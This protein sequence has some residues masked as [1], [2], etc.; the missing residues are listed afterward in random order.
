MVIATE[1]LEACRPRTLVAALVPVLLAS[2]LAARAEVFHPLAALLCLLFAVLLQI[3]TNFANDYYDGIKGT[4]G[5]GRLGPRRG[6]G[7]GAISASRMKDAMVGVLGAAFLVGLGLVTFGGWWLLPLGL[8][9][10]ALAVGYTGGPY[11]LAY[12]GLGDLFV[13]IFFGPVAT[14]L[15]YY[16]QAGEFSM[17]S[18]LLGLGSGALA[19]NLLVVNNV[20]DMD[21]DR[22]HGKRTT[23]VRFGR[24]FSIKQYFFSTVFALLVPGLLLLCG[25]G[26][27]VLFA[28]LVL[29]APGLHLCIA[30]A[31]SKPQQCNR[32]LAQ[33]G[34]FLIAYCL[35]L[36]LL[37][38]I[39]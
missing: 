28:S 6:V 9:F 8:L 14:L 26:P 13:L 11:P 17:S 23:A 18:F 24:F 22:L 16:V 37:L 12:L 33:T 38:V 1:W 36:S 15:T 7:S 27:V 3:G 4:D 20:R 10:I 30:L 35:L 31:R 5:A 39:S 21:L 34:K 2:A 32:L 25:I 19:S 29:L